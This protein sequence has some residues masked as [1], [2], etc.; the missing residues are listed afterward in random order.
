MGITFSSSLIF[1]A[2][3]GL[4]EIRGALLFLSCYYVPMKQV[5]VIAGPAGSGKV[6]AQTSIREY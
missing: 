3:Q 5:V 1:H 4:A 2:Y 6:A